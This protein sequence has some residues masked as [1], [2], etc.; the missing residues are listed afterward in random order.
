MKATVISGG[1]KLD[2]TIIKREIKNSYIICADSGIKNLR[3]LKIKPDLLLGDF[4][5]IEDLDRKKLEDKEIEILK[6]PKEKDGTDTEMAL[7]EAIKRGFDQITILAMSGTRLDHT[8]ANLFL[9]EKIYNKKIKA[10]AV[11]NNNEIIFAGPGQYI[12]KKDE[13]YKYI[14]LVPVSEEV[15]FSTENMAYEVKS[16]LIKRETSRAISNEMKKGKEASKII[17]EKGKTFIIRSVD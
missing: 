11:D 3:D 16:L 4:D 12:F 5:S 8:L 15:I 10:K 1:E 2:P 14:S 7:E 6:F 13:N 17:I 9:L